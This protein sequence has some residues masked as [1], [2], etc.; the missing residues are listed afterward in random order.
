MNYDREDFR[1][2]D[3]GYYKRRREIVSS[4]DGRKI[5]IITASGAENTKTTQK[6]RV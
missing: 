1:R 6:I 5:G 2:E 4:K 3:V